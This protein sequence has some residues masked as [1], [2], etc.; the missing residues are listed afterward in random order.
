[1]ICIFLGLLLQNF[2]KSLIVVQ[3]QVNQAFIAKELC[4]NRNK[5]Q[6]HCNG[7][8]HLK[9]ELDRDAQQEK[10]NNTGKDKYEVMFVETIHAFA[11]STPKNDITFTPFYKDPYL[12]TF[13]IS[14]FHPPQSV[15]A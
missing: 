2:S 4:E 1:M 6:M 13:A 12:N 7:R 14:I 9:K 11:P 5:P 10:N 8:C 3:F 15:V